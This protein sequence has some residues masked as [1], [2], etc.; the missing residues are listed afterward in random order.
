MSL[1]HGLLALLVAVIWGVNFLAIDLGL[2][3][4]PPLVLVALRFAAVAFPLVLI[5]PRPAMPWRSILAI[6]AF[7]SLGQ[8]AFV[9]TAMHL[10]LPAGLAPVVLQAQ[11]IFTIGIAA[12]VLRERPTRLQLAGAVIGVAG[13]AVVAAGRLD[14]APG[15]AA[16]GPLALCLAGALSWG[17]GNVVA[18]SAPPSSGL[19]IVVW[20]ALVVPVPALL[21]SLAI[22][23]P[24]SVG[25]A[26]AT[27]GWP[28]IGS[29]AFTAIAASLIGYSIWN[30]LLG[31]YPAAIVVPFALLVPPVGISA[32]WIVL[33]EVPNA[34]ELAGSAVLVAGV[35]LPT[36]VG[37]IGR[38]RRGASATAERA[39]ETA[40]AERVPEPAA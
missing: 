18:R 40:R 35:A 26:F 5:V 30:A 34:L 6:G 4:T 2:Q 28:T 19:G 7:M 38:R 20:S 25:E 1:R 11:M 37:M 17:V 36:V 21:A 23:G 24:A 14:A 29:V 39:A 22:D 16:L 8:F 15:L 12:A 32:A 3:D 27:I 33:G 31:R 10:G 9:F 13:L